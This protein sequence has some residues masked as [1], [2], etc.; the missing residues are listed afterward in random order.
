MKERRRRKGREEE[1][2]ITHD[3]GK[4]KKALINNMMR[5]FVSE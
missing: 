1:E 4:G 2:R 5:E 3:G